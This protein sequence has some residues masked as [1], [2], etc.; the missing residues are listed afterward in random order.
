[1]ILTVNCKYIIYKNFLVF[2][3]DLIIY[4]ISSY[5]LYRFNFYNS[6]TIS[7]F[8][9]FAIVVFILEV[10]SNYNYYKTAKVTIT[11]ETVHL[12]KGKFFKTSCSIP[13]KKVYIILEQQNIFMH[14]FG[15]KEVKFR[16]LAR[17]ISL[18]GVTETIN[19]TKSDYLYEVQTI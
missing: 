17:D 1:M 12:D 15:L 19:L 14:I 10:I 18:E 6:Y 16:T 8:S 3:G 7:G 13:I 5:L 11:K 4:L 9:I 2:F